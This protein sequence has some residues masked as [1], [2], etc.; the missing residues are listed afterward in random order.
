M[1]S[2]IFLEYHQCFCFPPVPYLLYI[3]RLYYIIT[4]RKHVVQFL[5]LSPPSIC[6]EIIS[7]D[8]E[9]SCTAL[10]LLKLKDE[11]YSQDKDR[12]QNSIEYPILNLGLSR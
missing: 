5:T 3:G 1:P 7:G 2:T 4:N 9:T 12:C 6:A 10:K 8:S 11:K